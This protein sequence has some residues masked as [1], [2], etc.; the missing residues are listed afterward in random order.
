MNHNMYISV[1][2]P[3][4]LYYLQYFSFFYSI[5]GAPA[6]RYSL[7]IQK[8]YRNLRQPLTSKLNLQISHRREQQDIPD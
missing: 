1:R 2:Q 3:F 5:P 8:G 6:A 4:I 7:N